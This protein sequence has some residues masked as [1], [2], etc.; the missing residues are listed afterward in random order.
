MFTLSASEEIW[1]QRE[2]A[3]ARVVA[4]E[5]EGDEVAVVDEV[6]AAVGA[7]QAQVEP[8]GHG[9]SAPVTLQVQVGGDVRRKDALRPC[10]RICLELNALAV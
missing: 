10:T 3:V 7:R 8:H 6:K 4:L 9:G 1:R 2:R 5:V